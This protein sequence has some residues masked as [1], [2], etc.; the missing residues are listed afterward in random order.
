MEAPKIYETVVG[1]TSHRPAKP[2]RQFSL[3]FFATLAAS[4]IL[5]LLV[6][7]QPVGGD[8]AAAAAA[9]WGIIFQLTRF[10]LIQ[11]C[12]KTSNQKRSNL[13]TVCEKAIRHFLAAS[14]RLFAFSLLNRT[15]CGAAGKRP[16]LHLYL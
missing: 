3:L 9:S 4:Y 16:K 15:G 12:N 1:L 10:A 6:S 8:A 11:R 2:T 5:V 13:K 7:G 14:K